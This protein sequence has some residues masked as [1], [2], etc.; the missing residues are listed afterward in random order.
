MKWHEQPHS[1]C[2]TTATSCNMFVPTHVNV[3]CIEK[4]A[5]YK[6]RVLHHAAESPISTTYR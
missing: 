3:R 1:G 5:T 4:H 2:N 6:I